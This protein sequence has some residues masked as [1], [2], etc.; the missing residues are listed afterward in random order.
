[1]INITENGGK[2]CGHT[3]FTLHLGDLFLDSRYFNTKTTYQNC[4]ERLSGAP[5]ILEIASDDLRKCKGESNLPDD[6]ILTGNYK[7]KCERW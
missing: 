4:E 5:R 2:I 7:R 6:F 3:R 1:M